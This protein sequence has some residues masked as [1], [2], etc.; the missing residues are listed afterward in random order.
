VQ[1]LPGKGMVP[2]WPEDVATQKPVYPT[3]EWNKR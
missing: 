3:P 2:V 1:L